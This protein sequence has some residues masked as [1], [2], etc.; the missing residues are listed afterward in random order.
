MALT[1]IGLNLAITSKQ[2]VRID[3]I[4]AHLGP[5]AEKW[6]NAFRNG[7]ALVITAVFFYSSFGMISGSAYQTSPAMGISM[8]I[9]Y[10]VLGSAS[11]CAVGFD[12]TIPYQA[13]G[14]PQGTRQE[15]GG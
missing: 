13:G 4:D 3:I 12:P 15:T 14:R 9:M 2:L 8:Q 5:S 7:A 1:L 11:S 6:L 10:S